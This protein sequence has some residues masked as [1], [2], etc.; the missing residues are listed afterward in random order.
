MELITGLGSAT[1][2]TALQDACWHRGIWSS[3]CILQFGNNLN[4]SIISNNEIQI[5]SGIGSVQG[6]FFI[7]EPNTYD[8]VTINNG[9]GGENRIDLIVAQYQKNEE[10]QVESMTWE[11][12]QGTP[13]AD[14]PVAPSYTQGNIDN[15][16]ILVQFPV[17]QVNIEGIT[18][19]SINTLMNI[20]AP[21]DD[22]TQPVLFEGAIQSGSI[23]LT[24]NIFNY[25]Y[26]IFRAGQQ[27]AAPFLTAT[28]PILQTPPPAQTIA[29]MHTED[30]QVHSTYMGRFNYNLSNPNTIFINNYITN[31]I[32]T[33]GSNH[34]GASSYYIRNIL[35]VR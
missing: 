9:T 23:T 14:T 27:A 31:V 35:G 11:V 12:I 3:D 32:H 26:L 10:T 18:L 20:V 13:S 17:F 21:V 4:P 7:V 28:L 30:A 34:R 15:G 2:I 16:D 6:R 1:H 33:S 24:D 29:F 5:Q 19:S 22:L 8:S 25:K